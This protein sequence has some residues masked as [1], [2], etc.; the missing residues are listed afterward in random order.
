M[1]CGIS[2]DG[3]VDSAS[4]LASEYDIVEIFHSVQG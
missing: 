4:D 3:D 2:G 1:H